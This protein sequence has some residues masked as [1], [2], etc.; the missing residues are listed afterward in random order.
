[1]AKKLLS[2]CANKREEY[3]KEVI[4]CLKY[5]GFIEVKELEHTHD[6]DFDSAVGINRETLP[7]KFLL[8]ATISAY[9]VRTDEVFIFV[10]REYNNRPVVYLRERIKNLGVLNSVTFK[11]TLDRLKHV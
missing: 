10:L 8:E 2:D 1:M 5:E 11:N 9:Y 4:E 3:V 6:R 7:S